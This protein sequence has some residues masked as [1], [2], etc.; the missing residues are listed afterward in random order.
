MKTLN[1]KTFTNEILRGK[2]EGVILRQPHSIYEQGSSKLVLKFKIFIDEEALVTR[3]KDSTYTCLMADGNTFRTRAIEENVQKKI[4]INDVISYKHAKTSP[5]G[6]P[7]RPRIY[8][9]RRDLTWNDVLANR[10]IIPK[11]SI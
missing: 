2:G 6:K 8:Q 7:I 11:K 9:F 5:S 3:I 1:M 10:A 4:Q